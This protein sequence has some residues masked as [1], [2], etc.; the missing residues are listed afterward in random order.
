M[1]MAYASSLGRLRAAEAVDDLLAL[2]Y[3]FRNEGAR[4][5]LAL[6][7]A[8]L[9]G[10]EHYYVQLT[11]QMRSDPGTATAQAVNAFHR[12]LDKQNVLDDETLDLLERCSDALARGNLNEGARLF[13]ELLTRL[14][15][16]E[17]LDATGVAIARACATELRRSGDEHPEYLFLALHTLHVAWR[18]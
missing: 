7:L 16:E 15:L 5:E 17:H 2:L 1:Q 3:R 6:D 13:G 8:R 18:D 14:P 10:D 12:Q 9:H 11:R 4:A